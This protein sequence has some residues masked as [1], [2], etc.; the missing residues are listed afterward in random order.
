MPL[1]SVLL[2]YRDAAATIGEALGSVFDQRAVPCPLE[3]VAIDDGSR[4]DGPRIVAARA[5]GGAKVVAV[6]TGG[7]GIARALAAGLAAAKGDLIARMDADDVA[8]PERLA[9]QVA[10]LLGDGRLAAVGCRVEAFPPDAVREGLSRYV[11][12]QNGLITPEDHARQI[13]VESPLCHPS[14]LL[15]REALDAVG[16]WHDPPWPEDYDLW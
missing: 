3:I 11:A 9:R 7:V 2:P 8:H 1:V 4:D 6:A 12:W 10:A 13:F 14:V 16:G 5:G 15:R